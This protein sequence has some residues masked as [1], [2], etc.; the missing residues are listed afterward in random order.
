MNKIQAL[1]NS[2]KR[3]KLILDRLEDK[4]NKT[5]FV[6]GIKKDIEKT[7]SLLKIE[8]QKKEKLEQRIIKVGS[9]LLITFLLCKCELA[10]TEDQVRFIEGV[11]EIHSNR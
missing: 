9:F 8:N 1:E 6:N 11:K 2:L 10:T 3:K 7:E 4:E 5:G